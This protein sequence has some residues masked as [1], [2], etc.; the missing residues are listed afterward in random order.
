[1]NFQGPNDLFLKLK[2]LC[3]SQFLLKN[4]SG[5]TIGLELEFFLLDQQNLPV[6]LTQSQEYLNQLLR[7][8]AD[9]KQ[10]VNFEE[11]IL[12]GKKCLSRVRLPTSELAWTSISYE[13]PPH[14]LELSLSYHG[15]LNELRDELL[16]TLNFL[17]ECARERKL[18]LGLCPR[19][20]QRQIAAIEKID[21]KLRD[22]QV[23]RPR[24]IG[25]VEFR[26]DAAQNTPEKIMNLAALRLGQYLLAMEDL[27]KI[28]PE[29]P[30]Y[31]KSATLWHEQMDANYL[32]EPGLRDAIWKLIH[33]QLASRGKGD[34]NFLLMP[35]KV[36]SP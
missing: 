31:E 17:H 34:E 9:L 20:D 28:L 15:G 5:P 8:H 13:Y 36:M 25:T 12:V 4:L 21:N 2:E 24:A 26:S 33:H 1:M 29:L 35:T 32:L 11:E 19:L 3:Q 16:K 6:G 18:R 27:D 23:I 7:D 10:T 14:F 30:N 22:L